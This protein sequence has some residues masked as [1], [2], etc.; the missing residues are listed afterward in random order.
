MSVA[1][2][3]NLAGRTALVTGASGG[4]GGVIAET[5]ASA[6]ASVF[7]SGRNASRLTTLQAKITTAGG[8][9]E[10]RIFDIADPISCRNCIEDVIDSAGAL[11][12]LI[13]CAGK[14]DRSAIREMS[15]AEWS[16]VLQTN[17][18]APFILSRAAALH[19]AQKQWGR[20]V[21]IGSVLSIQG[22]SGA[23]AYVT[24]KHGL[25][26]LTRAMA[27][28]LGGDG[29]CV[30]ALCP[31]YIR[32]EIN[33]TLQDD[34]IYS[35][36]IEA[37]TP[38]GRWGVPRDIAGPALFLSSEACAYVNGHLLMIDGGMTATH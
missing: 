32:T 29:V 5:L 24:S 35:A 14:I 1:S 4:I 17:L 34:P 9:A 31:G 22:K 25:A 20:I 26:G 30:N 21:N 36:K 8:A 2:L 10:T 18:N 23:A 19:M 3:F 6:G 16:S 38:A 7:L 11:D 27:A 13:N 15:D 12:I 33:T 28:E 37:A